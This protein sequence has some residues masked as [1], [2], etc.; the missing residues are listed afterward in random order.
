MNRKGAVLIFGLIVVLALSV[1]SASFYFKTINENTLARRHIESMRA[2]W[3]AEAGVAQAIN[4][5]PGLTA[6]GTLIADPRCA[7]SAQTTPLGGNLYRIV[8]T[9][10]VTMPSGQTISSSVTVDVKTGNVPASN[11]Q[12]AIETTTDL[13]I[14]GSVDINPDDKKKE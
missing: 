4:S 9:G 12:Y 3:A 14:K 11:F 7:Y 2:F 5:L 6:S 1:V 13:V 10:T 8:S